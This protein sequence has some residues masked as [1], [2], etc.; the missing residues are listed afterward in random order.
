MIKGRTPYVE[1]M[2]NEGPRALVR[3]F[4]R[5]YPHSRLERTCKK[6]IK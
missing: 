2:G 5:K 4:E 1:G 3:K 6:Y